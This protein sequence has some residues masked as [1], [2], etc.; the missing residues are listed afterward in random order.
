MTYCQSCGAPVE[1]KFCAKCGMAVGAGASQAPGATVPTEVPN[2]ISSV[3]AD[4]VASALCYVPLLGPLVFLLMAPYNKNKGIRFHAWQ[5]LFILALEIVAN[6]LASILVN[7]AYSLYFFHELVHL[8]FVLL[9]FYVG[10]KAYMGD[11][12]A[13]PVIGPL[14]EKQ[15]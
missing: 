10:Y 11:K 9:C 8:A 3:M 13:L 6:I 1:G 14:A 15:A 7:I 2:P 12:I 5:S 4:N